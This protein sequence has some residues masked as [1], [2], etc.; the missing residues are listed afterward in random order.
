MKMGTKRMQGSTTKHDLDIARFTG[1]EIL[2]V[3]FRLCPKPVLIVSQTGEIVIASMAAER[4]LGWPDGSLSRR[5]IDEIIPAEYRDQHRLDMRAFLVESEESE[6]PKRMRGGR[7]V[8]ALNG[9][10]ELIEVRITLMRYQACGYLF[11]LASLEAV[12]E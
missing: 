3:G 6:F 8:S 12:A 7:S 4:L 11:C 9:S 1:F 2:R 5:N 10:R